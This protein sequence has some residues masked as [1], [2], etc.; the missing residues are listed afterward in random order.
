[1]IY[2]KNKGSL[3]R[4]INEIV[5]FL[6][7]EILKFLIVQSFKIVCKWTKPSLIRYKNKVV[8]WLF[9]SA[10]K[11]AIKL[12]LISPKSILKVYVKSILSQAICWL[13]SF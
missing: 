5:E 11:T 7:K 6:L 2:N 13:K 1:M 12:R 9:F 8:S 4:S 3:A 10:I